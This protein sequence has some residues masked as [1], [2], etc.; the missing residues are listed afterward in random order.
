MLLVLS[1]RKADLTLYITLR[2]GFASR[3]SLIYTI[4]ESSIDWCEANYAFSPY[5]AV[6]ETDRWQNNAGQNQ[7][8]NIDLM[9][10][11]LELHLVHRHDT[12]WRD[13]ILQ[14][15]VKAVSIC[16]SSYYGCWGKTISRILN[17]FK[18]EWNK[19]PCRLTLFFVQIGS[20]LFHAT[21]NRYTQ[22]MV[23]NS[24]RR[25]KIFKAIQFH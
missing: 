18:G 2:A 3:A 25:R 6:C 7:N 23:K 15:S 11:I 1:R 12:S 22:A 9:L 19:K 21:L 10:G 4:M 20:F 5:I 16:I 17:F 24:S 8:V 14:D 13:Q